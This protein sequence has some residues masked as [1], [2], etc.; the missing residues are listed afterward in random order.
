MEADALTVELRD[1]FVI[2]L[3]EWAVLCRVKGGAV[4]IPHQ[5]I[6]G[7]S[8][9]DDNGHGTVLVSRRFAEDH[10]LL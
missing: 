5:E 10:Q 2:I 9:T 6:L 4:W 1:V 3:R 8:L 7:G